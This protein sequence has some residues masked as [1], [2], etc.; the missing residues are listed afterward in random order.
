MLYDIQ[1]RKKKRGGGGTVKLLKT[2]KNVFL[3][4][5]YKFKTRT[6]LYCSK[7]RLSRDNNARTQGWCCHFY[8]FTL[9]SACSIRVWYPR[10]VSVIFPFR[11]VIASGVVTESVHLRA[12]ARCASF[13]RKENC[14]LASK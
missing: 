9:I 14:C 4:F 10:V 5:I 2:I 13:F 7:G 8:F 12:S 11:A 6:V 3:F 1:R